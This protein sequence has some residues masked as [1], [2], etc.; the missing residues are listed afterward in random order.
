MATR[1]F[2]LDVFADAPFQGTQIPVV[3]PDRMLSS[4]EKLLIASE[5]QKSE[6]VF[7]D[8]ADVETPFSVYNDTRQTIFGAHTILAAAYIA[9]EMGLARD[10]GA[11]TAF[12]IVQNLQTI[13]VFIDKVPDGIGS[14]QF[15]RTLL[16]SFDRFTP[17]LNRIANALNID[18]KHISYS[19]YRPMVVSVDNP[20]L[21]IPFTRSEPVLAATPHI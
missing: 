12:D 14:I 4:N 2:L 9:H 19:K 17:S 18:E 21:I 8:T 1:Y 6:T 13:K 3:V 10:E 20:T 15:A 7:L 16:P 11:Y 5:F